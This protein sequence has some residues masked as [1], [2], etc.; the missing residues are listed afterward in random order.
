MASAAKIIKQLAKDGLLVEAPSS[1][2]QAASK[3]AEDYIARRFGENFRKDASKQAWFN[4]ITKEEQAAIGAAQWAKLPITEKIKI[5]AQKLGI[6]G[7]L[8]AGLAISGTSLLLSWASADNVAGSASF[9]ASR[10][11]SDYETKQ[12][13]G[14]LTPGDYENLIE[15]LDMLNAQISVAEGYS[16][17]ITSIPVLSQL[18]QPIIEGIKT[19]R[20]AFDTA[21]R[22]YYENPYAAKALTPEE[23]A[24]KF[25]DARAAAAGNSE[26]RDALMRT[27]ANRDA[28]LKSLLARG[29]NVGDSRD[30]EKYLQ[31]HPADKK[32]MDQYDLQA[33]AQEMMAKEDNKNTEVPEVTVVE[34]SEPPASAGGEKPLLSKTP[35]PAEEYGFSSAGQKMKTGTMNPLPADLASEA[36]TGLEFGGIKGAKSGAASGGIKGAL[37]GLVEPEAAVKGAVGGGTFAPVLIG[38]DQADFMSQFGM[39]VPSGQLSKEDLAKLKAQGKVL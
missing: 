34:K 19:Q 39:N 33:E 6:S 22:F 11:V 17:I 16:Q 36:S 15:Q 14:Q 32:T 12:K 37:K 30:L 9:A 4:I 24:R 20:I 10:A 7:F 29:V 28:F 3:K 8:K 21:T 23:E 13:N 26:E 5:A 1:L 38:S 31:E 25:N 35:L 27:F 18:N 2:E